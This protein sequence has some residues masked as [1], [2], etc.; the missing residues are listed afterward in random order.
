ML[1]FLNLQKKPSGCLPK[2]IEVSY[3]HRNPVFGINCGQKGLSMSAKVVHT[4]AEGK[5]DVHISRCGVHQVSIEEYK[6]LSYSN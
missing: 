3:Y 6:S 4:W 2:E 5:S 1:I